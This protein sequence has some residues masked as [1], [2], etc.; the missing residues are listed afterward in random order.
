[1]KAVGHLKCPSHFKSFITAILYAMNTL[2]REESDQQ[3]GF[4][5]NRTLGVPP[6]SSSLITLTLSSS[7]GYLLL[8]NKY[9]LLNG[10]VPK[11]GFILNTNLLFPTKLTLLSSSSYLPSSEPNSIP[12]ASSLAQLTYLA[13]L[14][15]LPLTHT[16]SNV[17]QLKNK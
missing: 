1:M 4:I 9:I 10:I 11:K 2:E 8:M 17:C 15:I 5:S 7:A 16:S 12:H 13:M 14:F 6:N 3:L